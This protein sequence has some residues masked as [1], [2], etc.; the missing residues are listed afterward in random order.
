[1]F[2]KITGPCS[3][4]S[5]STLFPNSSVVFANSVTNCTQC[6]LLSSRRHCGLWG[7]LGIIVPLHFSAR[8][9]A[10]SLGII[11]SGNTQDLPQ[12]LQSFYAAQRAGLD[13][14]V[15]LPRREAPRCLCLCGLLLWPGRRAWV[16][17]VRDGVEC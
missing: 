3:K 10:L 14:R 2:S 15:P 5:P 1:M 9:R 17:R 6:A 8:C 16:L 13:H 11:G 4:S 7:V 12:P